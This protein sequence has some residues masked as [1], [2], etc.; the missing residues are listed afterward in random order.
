M[1]GAFR[2]KE[3]RKVI[4]ILIVMSVLFLSLVVYLT[5]FE[6]FVKDR[7][8]TNSYNQRQWEAEED[9]IRGRIL[10]KNGIVL[11]DS[12]KTEDGWKRTYPHGSLY[13]HVIGYNSRTYGKSMLEASYND[14]L[15]G[16]ERGIFDFGNRD[17]SGMRYGDD[18]YLTLDHELQKL[19][20]Q[21]LGDRNGAVVAMNPKTGEILAL[22]SK[23][24]FD[25]N[26]DKLSAN[27]QAMVESE[28]A[29]FLPRATQGLYTP[30]STYKTVIS[31]GALENGMEDLVIE[32]KGTVTIDGKP[33]SNTGKKAYGKIDMKKALAVSSNVFF[34]Q[35]GVELG[36]NVLRSLADRFGL[37]K[38]IP[39]E[40][41]VTKSRFPYDSMGKTDMA[42]VAIGQGKLQVTPLHMAM[43]TSCIANN[44]VMMKPYMVSRVVSH[45]GDEIKV[46]EPSVLYNVMS[47]QTAGA[48]KLMMREV[49]KSGTGKSAAIE[50]VNVAGKTGSAENELTAEG[51]AKNHAWFISFAPVENPKIAVAVILEYS[52]TTGGGSAAPIARELMKAYLKK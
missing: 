43:I 51:E 9:T 21:L 48:I 7:I 52:G 18:V 16:S 42:S 11:A 27:W 34:S 3:D 41:P 39:F 20:S 25:P 36:E 24:A 13:S 45:D 1:K 2:M 28:D 46:T 38:D 26:E 5:Y 14:Y 37:G 47:T 19:A 30:G 35:V 4:H 44:G 50:G 6:L 32:D 23:P 8:I 12:P 15:L 29:I 31:A 49:V 22:V 33:F 10:D 17:E 40:I